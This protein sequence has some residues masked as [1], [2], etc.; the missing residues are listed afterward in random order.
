LASELASLNWIN[1][2]VGKLLADAV[3]LRVLQSLESKMKESSH[4]GVDEASASESKMLARRRSDE[5]ANQMRRRLRDLGLRSTRTRVALGN[6]LFAKGDRHIS[7]EMLFEE[8]SQAKVQVSLAT[9]YN[10]LH[11]FTEAGL[12]RQVAIDSSKSYFDTN[13]T[14]HHH[15][16]LEDKHELMDIPPSEVVAGKVPTPPAGY[17]VVRIDVVVRLR[18]KTINLAATN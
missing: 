11:Q 7:A 9:V 5:M 4:A 16:Y 6:I 12:L 14:E 10:T 17:E 13:N 2:K 18:R 15:Y 1:S 8:A 3:S